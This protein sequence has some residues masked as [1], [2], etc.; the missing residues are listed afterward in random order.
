MIDKAEPTDREAGPPPPSGKGE[1]NVALYEGVP[2][3]QS[4]ARIPEW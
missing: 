1:L 4:I 2:N 3:A